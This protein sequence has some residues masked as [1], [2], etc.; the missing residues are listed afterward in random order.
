[1]VDDQVATFRDQVNV[2][3]S[4]PD[5]PSD[6][7]TCDLLSVF[8]ARP[9]Q[10]GAG[11]PGHPLAG[12]GASP[13]G[14]SSTPG[15]DLQPARFEAQGSPAVL[16][17]PMD[18]L[19]ARAERLQYNLHDGQVYLEDHQEAALRKDRDEIHTPSLRYVPGPP[20]HKNMFQLLAGGP[21]WL[22]GEMSDRP[23]QQL[24]ARWKERLEVRPQQQ[25]QVISLTGG[26]SLSF[27]AMGQL[28]AREI[29]FRLREV[30]PTATP[31][32]NSVGWT[33]ES[34]RQTADGPGGPS[35]K[36]E[37]SF[38][39]D[40]L[41]AVGNVFGNSPQFSCKAE[42]RLD[43]WFTTAPPSPGGAVAA[44]YSGAAVPQYPFAAR[45]TLP[46]NVVPANGTYPSNDLNALPAPATAPAPYV[47]STASPAVAAYVPQ[48]AARSRRA[49]VAHGGL[50]TS[51]ES[52]GYSSRPPTGRSD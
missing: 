38:Q 12:R 29:H 49:A 19:E 5:G 50:R 15:F 18:R 28:D 25:Y 40:Q 41:F 23:G 3:R 36:G 37:A 21:G 35:H 4:H 52:L 27:Q 9:P 39:P 22:R 48:V 10:T 2:L 6:R 8:F 32:A 17:V 43:V 44:G 24:E 47:P 20:D 31:D 11:Q 14:K 42:E 30:P 33:S 46:G 51:A 34:V 13:K 45:A 26:A 16:T 1:M 7:L